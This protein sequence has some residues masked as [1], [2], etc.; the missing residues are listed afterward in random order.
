MNTVRRVTGFSLQ[1][2][3]LCKPEFLPILS[4]HSS[5]F[6][7]KYI[8]SCRDA[9]ISEPILCE[10]ISC[11]LS[12]TQIQSSVWIKP[13]YGTFVGSCN[14]RFRYWWEFVLL[15]SDYNS[16]I[17]IQIQGK[18]LNVKFLYSPNGLETYK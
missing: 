8:P 17:F 2:S 14:F 9:P 3:R 10:G 4:C 11:G 12:Y 15:L 6:C 16:T 13:I 1:G 18:V 7:S 5:V